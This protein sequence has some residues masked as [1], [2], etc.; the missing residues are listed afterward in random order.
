MCAPTAGQDPRLPILLVCLLL[1]ARDRKATPPIVRP[2]NDGYGLQAD[3]IL[4]LRRR[5][6]EAN[7]L[8]LHGPLKRMDPKSRDAAFHQ[9]YI[10]EDTSARVGGNHPFSKFCSLSSSGKYIIERLSHVNKADM[11]Q[12]PPSASKWELLNAL[13]LD[14]DVRTDRE[15]YALLKVHPQASILF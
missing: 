15:L 9:E 13:N 3:A 8:S 2:R 12:L 10:V 11:N 6:F 1:E 5:A 4:G 7:C 14:R